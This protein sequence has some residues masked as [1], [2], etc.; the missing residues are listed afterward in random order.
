MAPMVALM[1]SVHV[2]GHQ[3]D[4]DEGFKA[5]SCSPYECEGKKPEAGPCQWVAI[6]AHRYLRVRSRDGLG[7]RDPG[8]GDPECG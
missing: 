2:S 5:W 1:P 3:V 4:R 6:R 7:Q 8:T